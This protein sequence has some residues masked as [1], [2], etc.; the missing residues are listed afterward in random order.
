MRTVKE[1]VGN[2]IYG[3]K[4]NWKLEQRVGES[5]ETGFRH[6]N[7]YHKYF[8]G[9]T[10]VRSEKPNGR[11][12]ITRVYTDDWFVQD[13]S[14]PKWILTK[15]GLMGLSIVVMCMYIIVMTRPGYVVNVSQIVAIPGYMSILF[16]L[17]LCASTIGFAITKRKMT[18]WDHHSSTIR[19]KTLSAICAFMLFAT[20][21]MMGTVTIATSGSAKEWWLITGV[22]ACCACVIGINYFFKRIKFKRVVNNFVLPEGEAHRI[23]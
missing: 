3:V 18:W 9:Y 7:R 17:L 12:A 6:N 5:A 20:A 16:L 14:E 13:C 15:L 2:D 4:A 21:V 22:M 10:E 1:K 11:Y 19:I 8:H 23:S